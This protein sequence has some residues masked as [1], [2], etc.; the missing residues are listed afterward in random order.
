MANE[1]LGRQMAAMDLANQ[2]K[3]KTRTN[4]A[5]AEAE[6][7]R[8]AYMAQQQPQQ[9]PMQPQQPVQTPAPVTPPVQPVQ[10]T[11]SQQPVPQAT[12]VEPP[13][14]TV[15][16]II[17]PPVYQEPQP[18]QPQPTAQAAPV[19]NDSQRYLEDENRRLREEL[20]RSK[21][22]YAAAQQQAQQFT[23]MQDEMTL[24]EMF[25]KENIDLGGLDVN[26]A[27]TLLTPVF[28][29]VRNNTQTV[30]ERL[31]QEIEKRDAEHKKAME[32]MRTQQQQQSLM[33][34]FEKIK[35][36]HPDFEELQKT[37][38]YS[39][40]MASQADDGSGVFTVSLVDRAYRNGNHEYVINVLDRIKKMRSDIGDM[41]VVNPTTAGGMATAS[42]SSTASDILTEEQMFQIRQDSIN[43]RNGWN[44]EKMKEA[45]DR[46]KEA[47][48]A[49]AFAN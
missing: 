36:A 21:Q 8:A 24:R 23:S 37:P 15:P 31:K 11:Q 33:R 4:F 27:V 3:P 47:S 9:P 42:A 35:K 45:F 10:Q 29:A 43:N 26:T 7:E 25:T 41:A 13:A 12:S 1:D 46:H 16:P 20:E 34:T 5:K 19:Q 49:A 44:R 28:S 14:M 18:P 32:E 40:V 22:A 6:K 2:V 30:E 39:K 48:A 38:E 17:Q